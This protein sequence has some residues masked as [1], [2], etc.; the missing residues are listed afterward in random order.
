MVVTESKYGSPPA[1]GAG[2]DRR[3]SLVA[4]RTLSTG[5]NEQSQTATRP[6]R[7]VPFRFSREA[8]DRKHSA[9]GRYAAERPVQEQK[10]AASRRFLY[11][12]CVWRFAWDGCFQ[13]VWF[14]IDRRHLLR[15]PVLGRNRLGRLA[16][17]GTFASIETPPR[18]GPRVSLLFPTAGGPGAS[19]ARRFVY[20]HAHAE[21]S[22]C[23][24][25]KAARGR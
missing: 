11:T 15:R 6:N 2:N 3:F 21:Q 18:A 19:L 10:P 8:H 9:L 5:A 4:R 24:H 14:E 20:G 13:A 16:G 25:L 22:Q 23:G 17:V 12:P 1:K 7:P